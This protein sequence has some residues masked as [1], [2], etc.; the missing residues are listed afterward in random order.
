MNPPEVSISTLAGRGIFFDGL[1]AARHDVA[2]E[3][4]PAALRLHALDGTILAEWG[5]DEL[6]TL[7]APDEVLRLGK[8]GNTVLARLEV[9][10][11]ALAA[12][13]DERSAPV[14]R[15][16][17]IDR[18][19]RDKVIFW[20]LAATLSL[21]LVAILGMPLLATALTPLVP[22]AVERKLGAA[23]ATQARTSLDSH[24]AGA[25]FECGHVQSEQ[26]GRAAFDKLL[27]Q[28]EAGAKLPWPLT[29]MIVRRPEANAITFPGGHIYVFEG[30]VKNAD[31]PDELAGVLAHEI[32]HVAHHD[33]TRTVIQ[34]AG[35]SLLF[36]V[37]LGDFVGGGAVILAAKTI[38]QTSYSREVEAA[39]DKY[40]V[41]LMARI[42]GD[43]R[44]L[45]TI[46]MRIAGTTHPGPTIL[47][48]H[49]E[50]RDRVAAI[51]AM[52][53]TTP[54]P[55]RALLEQ[56]QWAALKAVCVRA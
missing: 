55:R 4:A 15:T 31:T 32:G 49:P 16:G 51:E 23:V 6:E 24:R 14:D 43:P 2:V 29:V 54:G 50:T 33:G 40:G 25:A 26:A 20:S 53:A 36:G 56:T 5:Y 19:L 3:L 45:G 27:G 38:L 17:R 41:T 12:A 30:L 44:A 13:I 34:G 18:R 21:V 46:L 9:K 42:G 48:D 10:E 37:L 7:S 1:T 28:I 47:A 11:P 22:Y 35:L 52:A 39:A 8:A